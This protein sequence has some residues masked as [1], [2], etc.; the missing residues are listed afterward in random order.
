MSEQPSQLH[1]QVP[2]GAGNVSYDT[3]GNSIMPYGLTQA[4]KHVKAKPRFAEFSSTTLE[5]S[6]PVSVSYRSVSLSLHQR[7]I[8]MWPL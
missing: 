8:V 3:E 5:V 1:S 2:L 4:E 6:Q 7:S